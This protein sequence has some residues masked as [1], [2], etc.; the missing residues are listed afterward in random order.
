MRL[1][2]AKDKTMCI[3][4]PMSQV[5]LSGLDLRV[6]QISSF[7]G[8]ETSGFSTINTTLCPVEAPEKALKR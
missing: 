6:I 5:R 7:E 3:Q 4:F 1:A 2:A 8:V